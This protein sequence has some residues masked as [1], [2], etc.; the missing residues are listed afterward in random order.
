ML[1][2]RLWRTL[3]VRAGTRP[4]PH[5]VPPTAWMHLARPAEPQVAGEHGLAFGVEGAGPLDLAAV[6]DDRE[7]VAHVAPHLRDRQA[8]LRVPAQ[9]PLGAAARPADEPVAGVDV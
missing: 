2:R 5:G 1:L 4:A 7:P 8:R 3:G 6:E 9:P